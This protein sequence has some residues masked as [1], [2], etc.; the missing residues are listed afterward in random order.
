MVEAPK[1][2][3]NI[4]RGEGFAKPLVSAATIGLAATRRGKNEYYYAAL[5]LALLFG[6]VPGAS[7]SLRPWLHYRR[8]FG[9]R[10]TV[11]RCHGTFRFSTMSMALLGVNDDMAR[12]E[13]IQNEVSQIADRGL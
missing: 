12:L 5:R 9:A 3:R 7:Q 13:S 8:T 1:V 10:I 2:R 4:A 11:Q 6:L